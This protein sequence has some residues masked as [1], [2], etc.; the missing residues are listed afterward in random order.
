MTMILHGQ[1]LNTGI[2]FHYNDGLG[3]HENGDETASSKN[4]RTTL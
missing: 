1:L 3:F 4:V 2:R